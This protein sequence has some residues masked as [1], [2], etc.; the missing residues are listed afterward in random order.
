MATVITI[1]SI[2]CAAVA[3]PMVFDLTLVAETSQRMTKHTGPREQPEFVS[4]ELSIYRKR[5][6]HKRNSRWASGQTVP[7]WSTVYFHNLEHNRGC[8]WSAAVWLEKP[9]RRYKC[10]F[11]LCM[12]VVPKT[13]A[14]QRSRAPES[15]PTCWSFD[16]LAGL[17]AERSKLPTRMLARRSMHASLQHT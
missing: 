3:I 6:H 8:Q 5:T 4:F 1:P 17:L 7:R 13:E 10:V 9:N 11:D 12:W 16:L 15:R 2:A 14:C